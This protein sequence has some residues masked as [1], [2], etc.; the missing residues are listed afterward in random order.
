MRRVK[1]ISGA[2]ILSTP[3]CTDLRHKIAATVLAQRRGNGNGTSKEEVCKLEGE[4]TGNL[5][6]VPSC[7]LLRK[8]EHVRWLKMFWR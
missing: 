6:P 1:A 4:A 5:S 3:F 8:V 7:Q 2:F